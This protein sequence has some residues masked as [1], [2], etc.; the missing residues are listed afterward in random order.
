MFQ[1]SGSILFHLGDLKESMNIFMLLVVEFYRY[2]LGLPGK[3]SDDFE[4]MAPEFKEEMR[5]FYW[6]VDMGIDL[7]LWI[8]SFDTGPTSTPRF[9]FVQWLDEVFN[10][11]RSTH[12]GLICLLDAMEELSF[13]IF[14][15][16]IAL[17]NSKQR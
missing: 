5:R 4:M 13:A 15:Y 2:H 16:N 3:D 7:Q 12:N 11:L 14:D 1:Q 10:P 8:E 9:R 6:T 17:A